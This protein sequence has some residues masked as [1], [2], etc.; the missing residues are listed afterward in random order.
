MLKTLEKKIK[1]V[2]T[3]IQVN[4][5]KSHT[6]YKAVIEQVLITFYQA[7]E[8]S[9]KF[10]IKSYKKCLS[11]LA[12]VIE[13]GINKKSSRRITNR[14]LAVEALTMRSHIY[15]NLAYIDPTNFSTH[16]EM[17]LSDANEAI[18]FSH[19]LKQLE[20][21]SQIAIGLIYRDKYENINPT[22]DFSKKNHESISWLHLN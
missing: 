10:K 14:R 6:Y 7:N 11:Q 2:K 20:S 18:Q 22:S 19:D 15:R 5:S 3:T 16:I 21:E 1:E 4:V 9:I 17:A 12:E 8:E 13:F